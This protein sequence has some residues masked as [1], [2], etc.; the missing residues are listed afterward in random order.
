MAGI[1]KQMPMV[2]QSSAG[3]LTLI[4]EFLIGFC[5]G[6]ANII[7]GVSGGT[8]LLVFGIYERV[9]SILA[10]INKDNLLNL[11]SISAQLVLRPGRDSL[12]AV[13]RFLTEKD[14]IFLIKLLVG[15][16][17]A[18]VALSSLMKYL[19]LNR[20]TVTYALFFGLI[21]LSVMVPVRMLKTRKIQWLFFAAAGALATVWLTA[22]VDPYQ[23]TKLKSEM[24]K[25]QYL[26]SASDHQTAA[27]SPTEKK[28]SARALTFS[29]KYAPDEYLYAGLCGAVSISA[30]VLP[31][32]SGSLVLILMGQYFEVVS[33]I[34]D[35]RTLNL[36]AVLF[37]SCFTLGIV[38]G[39][40]FFARIINWVLK[41]YYD[42]TMAV[43]TGLMVGS[44]YALWPFK[45]S[46]V[47]AHQYIKKD[48]YIHV[49]E[50]VRVYTNVNVLPQSFSELAIPLA[51]FAA[52]CLIMSFFV[53]KKQTG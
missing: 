16:V 3:R 48:G 32:V 33:A 42:A 39:G 23:K 53:G 29:G 10:N 52:G 30:M 17:V 4:Q 26:S 41:K 20:F 40:L 7:P 22:A 43:L 34:S 1:N 5:L 6:C 19:I 2:S 47:L 25:D 46:V 8:F 35:L 13:Q 9:F 21:F 27:A 45:K 38:F 51:A 31:G 49:L 24:L 12:N 14:F 36:D 44:L 15:S 11:V 50:N 28:L 18:I 37:L